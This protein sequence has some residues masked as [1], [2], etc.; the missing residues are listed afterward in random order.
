MSKSD[1]PNV[2]QADTARPSEPFNLQQ[3]PSNLQ[4]E[5]FNLQQEPSNLQQEPSNLQ[6]APPEMKEHRERTSKACIPGI[7]KHSAVATSSQDAGLDEMVDKLR[8][9]VIGTSKGGAA[10]A[11][12]DGQTSAGKM[13]DE[14]PKPKFGPPNKPKTLHATRDMDIDEEPYPP[15]VRPK[16]LVCKPIPANICYCLVY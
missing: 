10:V 7:L 2:T 11:T 6:Q 1:T 3:E 8:T 13:Y 4:Q 14:V 5:P 15:Y 9:A 16:K 12:T